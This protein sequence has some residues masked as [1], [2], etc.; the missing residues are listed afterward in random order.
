MIARVAAAPILDHHAVRLVLLVRLHA[1]AACR[2]VQQV[3]E[4]LQLPRIAEERLVPA[5][6]IEQRDHHVARRPAPLDDLQILAKRHQP[7]ET[8]FELGAGQLR[9]VLELEHAR[10]GGPLQQPLLHVALVADEELA[11]AALGAEERRLRDVDVAGLDQQPH[12][13]VE[14]RQQQRADVRSVHVRVGHDDDAVVAQLGEVEVLDA[15]PA[16]ERRDHRLDLVAPKHLVEARLLDVQDL[17]LDRQDRLELPVASLLGRAAGRLPFDDVDLAEGGIALLAVGQLA[18]QAAAVQCALAA[19]QVAGFARR[20]A[21]PRRVDRLVDDPLGDRR[22]LFEERPQLVVDDRF[23]DPLD[24]GVT[25]L[26]LGLPFE[27]RPRDLDADHRDETLADV[28]AAD[29]GVLQVLR[30]VVLAGVVVD[31]AG[32]RRAEPREVRAAFV[33]VDVVGEGVDRLHVAVV[34]LQRQLDVDA[35]L[36]A[37]H[38]DRLVV[39]RRLVQVQVL[40]ERA[41]PAGIEEVMALAV[42]LVVDRDRHAAVQEG[43]LAQPLGQRVEA[44]LGGL[45][46]LRIRLEGDLGAA[47]LGRTGD[48][49]LGLRIAA[50][51]RLRVHLLV[52]PDLEIEGLRERVYDRDADPVQSAGHL[53]AVVVELA[54]GMKHG[55]RDFGRRLT[56]AVAIDRDAAAVVDHRDRLVDMDRDVDL[57]AIAG[58]RLVYRVVDDFVDEMVQAGGAGRADVHRRTLTDRLEALEDLDLVGAVIVRVRGLPVGRRR[59]RVLRGRSR[60][61]AAAAGRAEVLVQTLIVRVSVHSSAV[62]TGR[63]HEPARDRTWLPSD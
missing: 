28:V 31:R 30:Q 59:V 54:A 53:V 61:R 26:G 7:L 29:V 57:I 37:V 32:Q 41:D 3:G 5:V 38:V 20:L 9:S 13:A 56:A 25:E 16:P 58:Q 63:S 47:F 48:R 1:G 40:D 35:V 33:R 8:R 36:L 11:A 18:R 62:M 49:E 2:A 21:G 14:E 15:D 52:A 23:D 46:D 12:L 43:Q 17:A 45:E 39:D 19:D 34:P 27:L 24:L 4:L 44:E 22:V 10:F 42:A 60:M 50:L 6:A 51:V 55:Q